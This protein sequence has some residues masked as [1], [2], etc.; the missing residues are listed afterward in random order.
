MTATFVERAPMWDFWVDRGGTFTDVV[1]RDPAGGLQAAK[2]LSENPEAYPDAAVE[3]IRRFLE[4]PRGA[5]I[6]A[7]PDR[8]GEDGHHCRHQRAAG[9]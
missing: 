8:C 3:A 4:V 9:A 2:L 5:P 7:G 1:A 6:P